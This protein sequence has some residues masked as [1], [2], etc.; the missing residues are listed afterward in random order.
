MGLEVP[1]E[2]WR[3]F[4][5]RGVLIL[6]L[7]IEEGVFTWGSVGRALAEMG[8]VHVLAE[9][10]GKTAA[11]MLREGAVSRLELFLAPRIL[12]ASGVSSVGDLGGISLKDAPSLSWR[13]VRMIGEDVQVTADVK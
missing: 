6:R 3:P 2:K 11:W 9:G 10:G 8:I 5:D 7:P 4:E 12:G 1:E 13:R